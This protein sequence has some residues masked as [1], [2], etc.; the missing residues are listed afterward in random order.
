MEVPLTVGGTSR[1]RPARILMRSAADGS[2]TNPC[3]GL[4]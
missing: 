1:A 4:K 3:N 2:L